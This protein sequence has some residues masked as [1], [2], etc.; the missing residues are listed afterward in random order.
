[1]GDYK[2]LSFPEQYEEIQ[3]L[4]E[5]DIFIPSMDYEAVFMQNH[6]MELRNTEKV[7]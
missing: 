4:E 5:S 7:L 3:P 6:S 2:Q 1:M